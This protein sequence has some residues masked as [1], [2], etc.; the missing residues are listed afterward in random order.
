MEEE[1]KERAGRSAKLCIAILFFMCIYARMIYSTVSSGSGFSVKKSANVTDIAIY[2][3]IDGRYFQG[4]LLKE[5][6]EVM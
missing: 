3:S 4:E 2:G 6:K 5:T 1:V